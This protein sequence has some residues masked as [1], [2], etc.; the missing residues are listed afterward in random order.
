MHR[1]LLRQALP[2]LFCSGPRLMGHA[3]A[4]AAGVA[5]GRGAQR[6]AQHARRG[7]GGHLGGQRRRHRPPAHQVGVRCDPL[8]GYILAFSCV[9]RGADHASAAVLL[10]PCIHAGRWMRRW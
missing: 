7:A 3:Q 5:A 2:H 8:F 9:G 10:S 6:V 1:K 4:W